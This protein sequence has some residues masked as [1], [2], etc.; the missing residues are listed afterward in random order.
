VNGISLVQAIT[1]DRM[2]GRM[3][4]SR[5]FVVWG[6]IPFGGLSGGALGSAVGLRTA[7]WVGAVGQSIAFLPVLFSPIR[8]IRVIADGEALAERSASVGGPV[9]T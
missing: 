1:P 5:R 3:K 2:L 4:A 9:S 6:V 7:L 8:H